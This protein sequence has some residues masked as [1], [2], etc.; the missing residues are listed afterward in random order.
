MSESRVLGVDNQTSAD[1]VNCDLETVDDNSCW[2]YGVQL[3]V[4]NNR[5]GFSH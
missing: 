1:F 3:N 5:V 4:V 2:D